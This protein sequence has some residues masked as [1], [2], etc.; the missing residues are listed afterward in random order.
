MQWTPLHG[1]IQDAC[2]RRQ[3]LH[4]DQPAQPRERNC[5]PCAPSPAASCRV[6]RSL[7]L[8]DFCHDVCLS[9]LEI[10]RLGDC[11]NLIISQAP[12]LSISPISPQHPPQ[13]DHR[14]CCQIGRIRD[15]RLARGAAG[16]QQQQQRRAAA[17]QR[18]CGE[19]GIS[20]SGHPVISPITP[21]SFTSP[22]PNAPRPSTPSRKKRPKPTPPPSRALVGVR[23]RGQETEGHGCRRRRQPASR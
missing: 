10:E 2:A 21:A 17:Q 14:A 19:R 15:L 22:K 16:E 18:A 5:P 20:T 11:H 6:S 4:A 9:W 23:R 7:T 1:R 12:I 13:R 8:I 3:L